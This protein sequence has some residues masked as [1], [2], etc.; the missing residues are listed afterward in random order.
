MYIHTESRHLHYLLYYSWTEFRR[1]NSEVS[2]TLTISVKGELNKFFSLIVT[3]IHLKNVHDS[4][5]GT[6][7]R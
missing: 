7:T 1:Q 3:N 6:L 2:C 5:F 4:S